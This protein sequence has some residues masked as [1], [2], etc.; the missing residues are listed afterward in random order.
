LLTQHRERPIYTD[1][2]RTFLSRL[3]KRPW[4]FT[5]FILGSLGTLAGIAVLL[6]ALVLWPTLPSID[7]IGEDKLKIPLRVYSAE[8]RLIGEF[9]EEKRI[10]VDI[11]EVPKDLIHAIIATE[12]KNFYSHWGVDF[13]G[14]AR[15]MVANLISGRKGQGASTITM[16]VARNFFL[17]PKRT[18]T[19]KFKEMLLAFKLEGN[20]TK[21]QIL[22][23][24]LNKIYLGQR[25]YGFAAAAKIYYGKK[26]NE[27]E[28][29]EMAM[30]AGLPKAPSRD[31]PISNPENALDRRNHVLRRLLEQEYIDQE[32]FDKATVAP[33]TASR[34]RFEYDVDAPYI[35][36]MVRRYMYRTYREKSY[37]GGFH[38]HTTIRADDQNAANAAVRSGLLEYE[39]RH[40]YR[41]RV[42]KIKIGSVLNKEL[43]D[44]TLA[45]HR[46]IGGLTPSVIVLVD[47]KNALAY[48]QE[49]YVVELKWDDISWARRY[50]N[51]NTVGRRP[52]K[53]GDVLHQGDIVYLQELDSNRWMLAQVPKVSG[54][55][56]A[57]RPA[58]GAILALT[59]GFDFD[60]SHFNRVEQAERQPG[61]NIKPFIYSA[62]LE[63]GYTA[64]STI[65]GA[66]IVIK[67]DNL[68]GTWRP[69]NYGHKFFGPTRLRKALMLSIN[70]VSVRLLRSIGIKPA[71]QHLERFGFDGNKLPH[72]LSLALGSGSLTPL[73]VVSGFGVFA[74]GG[75]KVEPYFIA[76]ITDGEGNVIE[77]ANPLLVCPDCPETQVRYGPLNTGEDSSTGSDESQPKDQPGNADQNKVTTAAIKPTDDLSLTGNLAKEPDTD[78]SKDEDAKPAEPVYVPR[79]APRMVRPENIYIMTTILRDVIKRGTGQRAKVLGRDDLGGKTGTTNDFKDAWFSGFNQDVVATAWVGFDQPSTLGHGEAGSRAALPIWVDFMRTALKHSKEEPLAMPDNVVSVYV[80]PE[81]G[82]A[83]NATLASTLPDESQTE[84]ETKPADTNLSPDNAT[85]ENGDQPAVTDMSEFDDPDAEKEKEN[86]L[87]PIE[88]YFIKGTEPKV[89]IT[90][91]GEQ[92]AVDTAPDPD[93]LRGL[94]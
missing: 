42:G 76:N 40:G 68:E 19:R 92:K 13:R 31:N 41:G 87:P 51:V 56:V 65:S 88:E 75:F 44:D 58:D 52:R 15:A 91:T 47:N 21:D 64:A 86:K 30:L 54:A 78:E 24:Y 12:D 73:E 23:L 74:N 8:G 43:M 90:D 9:G 11:G 71:I 26:L 45:G 80:D 60:Q 3:A 20:F 93:K 4:L 2:I 33:I 79:F 85:D 63:N 46:V 18:Y 57:L 62:A 69:E 48:T 70:T 1:K 61:S 32:T 5:V 83:V 50:V 89:E 34:H 59:G 84:P 17:S 36:E 6:L 81:T 77:Q 14:I 53:A 39:R 37:A 35:A 72:N 22:E 66:P 7:N 27:L 55:L 94:F 38:V 82:K 29:P 67:D 28:L 16:Q 10:P 25:A 49:G